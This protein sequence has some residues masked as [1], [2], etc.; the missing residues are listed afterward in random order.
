MEEEA[1][2]RLGEHV[3]KSSSPIEQK[4]DSCNVCAAIFSL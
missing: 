4:L 1:G 2:R 3:E